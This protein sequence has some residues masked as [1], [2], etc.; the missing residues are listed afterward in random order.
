MSENM[1]ALTNPTITNPFEALALDLHCPI[2]LQLYSEPVSLPC[3]HFYCHGCIQILGE[4]LDHHR[5][6]ECQASYEGSQSVVTCSKLCSIIK[7]YKAFVGKAKLPPCGAVVDQCKR[8]CHLEATKQTPL[9]GENHFKSKEVSLTRFQLASQATDLARQLELSEDMLRNEKEQE[10]ELTGANKLLREKMAEHLWQLNDEVLKYRME[11]MK[12]LDE[13]LSPGETSVSHRVGQAAGMT[14][15]LRQVLLRAESL[16][17][18][19]DEAM[20]AKDLQDLQPHISE[21]MGKAIGEAEDCVESK[22]NTLQVISKLEHMNGELRKSLGAIHRSIRNTFNP[23]EVTFDVGTAHPNLIVSEDLK[24]VTFSSVKQP[25]PP[26]PQRFTS[27]FQVLSSQSFS[28]G[29][30]CWEVEL[31]GSPWI[32][33]LCC[34]EKLERSGIS[35]ALESNQSSWCLMWFDNLLTAF[36]R[37]R[38]VPLKRTTVSCRIEI[39]LGF[40]S[41]TLSFYNISPTSGKTLLNKF[42][43]NLTEPVRLAYRM[44]SGHPKARVTIIS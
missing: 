44:M 38:D 42:E 2:C 31:D 1:S 34:S 41:R 33:G 6:P 23:S 3:G 35:S 17:T 18:E 24:S 36:E 32:V 43:A 27:F 15:Q 19:G 9:S 11:V 29:D 8:K 26:S 12:M 5:C 13:E 14:K 25:Y 37:G 16:L 39:R 30:H 7:S 20:F 28:E 10:L 40:S 22:F 4:R 21:M